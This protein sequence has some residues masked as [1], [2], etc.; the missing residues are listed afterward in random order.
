M[1]AALDGNAGPVVALPPARLTA[2][3]QQLVASL[4]Q[5]PVY[6]AA[7]PVWS[8]CKATEMAVT[9]LI[10][11]LPE[12]ELFCTRQHRLA[13]ERVAAVRAQLQRAMANPPSLEEL[14]REIAHFYLTHFRRTSAR[15]PAIPAPVDGP[16]G[17]II[18][19]GPA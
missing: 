1:R 9:F 12:A 8:Q 18:A 6:A 10:Q 16:G 19:G 4:R 14:G 3:Q 7:Q 2:A 17:G 11:P 15:P 13:Q 5:P